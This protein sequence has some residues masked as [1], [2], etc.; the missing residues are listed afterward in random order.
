MGIESEEDV[1][2]MTEFF[3]KYKQLGREQRDHEVSE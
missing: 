2:R 1:Y 3:M